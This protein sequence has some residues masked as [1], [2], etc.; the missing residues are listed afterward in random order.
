M[1]KIILL[2]EKRDDVKNEQRG[3]CTKAMGG[4]G[5]KGSKKIVTIPAFT[6]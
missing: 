6:H 3:L 1:A 2:S 5:E 4:D